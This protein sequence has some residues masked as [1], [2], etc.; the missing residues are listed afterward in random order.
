MNEI[1]QRS[2]IYGYSFSSHC[3]IYKPKAYA[4]RDSWQRSIDEKLS[5]FEYI[6]SIEWSVILPH[7]KFSITWY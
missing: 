5:G 1:K 2:N 4:K 3:Y 6:R 7:F